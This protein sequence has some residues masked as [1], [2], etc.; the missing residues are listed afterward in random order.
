MDVSIESVLVHLDPRTNVTG[1]LD[2]ALELARQHRAHV[3]GLWPSAEAGSERS[4]LEQTFRERA[5]R[6]QL[7]HEWSRVAGNEAA[8]LVLESRCHDLLVIG[9][10]DP[11]EGQ[12]WPQAQHLLESALLKSGHSLIAVPRSGAFPSVGE[13]ILV[14]WDG[15][16]EAARAVEDAMP[17]LE[18]AEQV[19]L[20]TVDL[21]SGEAL[22]ADHLVVL[23][24]RH[25]VQISVQGARS[26][27]AAIGE[28]LLGRARELSCDLLVMGGYGHSPLR[29]HLFGG[30]TY[31]VLRHM[32]VPVLLSH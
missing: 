18:R 32:N 19:T 22:S 14:A 20:V 27:G 12:F 3:V 8:I 28:V 17:I 13:R 30:P 5:K 1:V 23:L 21:R 11:R 24:E 7:S 31:F 10:A 2:V 26:H 16:R 4:P 9:Q 29:E 25:G 15:A 6:L